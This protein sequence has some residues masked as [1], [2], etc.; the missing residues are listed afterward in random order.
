ME[1]NLVRTENDALNIFFFELVDRIMTCT[2]KTKSE[3]IV[4]KYY[5]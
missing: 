5:F 2:A 1:I 4:V 3:S